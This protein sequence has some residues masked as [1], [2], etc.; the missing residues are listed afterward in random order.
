MKRITFKQ[1]MSIVVAELRENGRWGTAH[2]Y[3]A[4]TRSFLSFLQSDS[5]LLCRITPALLK[6]YEEHLRQQGRQW[7]TIS[8]YMRTL[9]AL[10][11]RGVDRK[12]APVAPRLFEH[13]YT[14]TRV[15]SKRALSAQEMSKVL[16]AAEACNSPL[17]T[18]SKQQQ[19]ASLLFSLMF[20]LRGIPFVDL[21]YLRKEDYAGGV[22]TYR[23]RKTGRLL[24]VVVPP[25]ARRVI[26]AFRSLNPSSPYLLPLMQGMGD[27]EQ[28]YREYQSLLRHLNQSLK[29][30]GREL[31]LTS[32]LSSYAARHTWAT[33]AYYCEIHP[34]IISEAMGH[35]SITVTE[36]YLKPFRDE[37]IDEANRQVIAF[38]RREGRTK[39]A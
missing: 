32:S 30:L 7:N 38:V 35:S 4:T 28:R 37:R 16:R 3:Q 11:N 20:L 33:M 9:R 22:I 29:L 27:S 18:G 17:S 15:E 34:G 12:W 2:I 21:V 13:V 8:T 14:G 23:R 6:A 31:G 24:S 19:Q 1:A 5:L 39:R 10:Y 25:E 36:T 26:D